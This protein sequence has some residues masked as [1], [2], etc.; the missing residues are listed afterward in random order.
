MNNTHKEGIMAYINLKL[1]LAHYDTMVELAVPCPK[2][3]DVALA[4]K[5]VGEAHGWQRRHRHS[6]FGLPKTTA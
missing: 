4:L 2:T 6:G 5:L 3:H 1:L